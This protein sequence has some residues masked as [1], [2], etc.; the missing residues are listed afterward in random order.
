[1]LPRSFTTRIERHHKLWL[2]DALHLKPSTNGGIDMAGGNF[3]G[4]LKAKLRKASQSF[5][6]ATYQVNDFE[7]ANREMGFMGRNVGKQCEEL[8][9]FFAFLYYD[10]NYSIDKLHDD[11]ELGQYINNREAWL[12]PWEWVKGK[13][14]P[15]EDRKYLCV[16]SNEI[17]RSFNFAFHPRPGGLIYASQDSVLER[18]L[19][20]SS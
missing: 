2:C 13:L 6:V 11:E 17:K 1:M 9:L 16:T 20:A 15:E 18:R 7:K 10:F 5:S 19:F 8:V 12:V 4:E 3:R 14:R